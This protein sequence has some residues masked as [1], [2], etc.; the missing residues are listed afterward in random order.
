MRFAGPCPACAAELREKFRGEAR[1]VEGAAYEPEMNVTPNAVALRTTERRAGRY[2]RRYVR[3]D[4][5]PRL[6]DVDFYD[7]LGVDV[8]RVGDEIA[9]AFRAAAKQLASRRDRRPGR[10]RAFK[11]LAAAY[12]VLSDHRTPPRLR[13]RPGGR[14]RAARRRRSAAGARDR[15]HA[16]ATRWTRRRAWTAVVGGL[17]VTVLGV[18]RG[19]RHVVPP[20][21]RRGRAGAVRAGHRRARRRRRHHVRRPRDGQRVVARASRT[22]HGDPTGTGPDRARCATTRRTRTHVIVDSSTFGRDITLAIVAIKF[23]IGGPVFV[24]LGARHLRARA[25]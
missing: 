21:S 22:Q 15:G 1:E 18:A 13:P 16:G 2:R 17:V 10:G 4:A 8:R 11:D 14:R 25:S 3:D 6:G 19:R 5:G 20:R 9:R 24:V 23:L 12:T 7:L